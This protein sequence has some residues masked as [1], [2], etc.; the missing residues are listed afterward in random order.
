[1]LWPYRLVFLGLLLLLAGTGLLYSHGDFLFSLL[2]FLVPYGVACV[3]IAYRLAERLSP[4]EWVEP[5]YGDVEP[6]GGDPMP[7]E[8]PG[9]PRWSPAPPRRGGAR[10]PGHGEPPVLEERRGE[11]RGETGGG[12]EERGPCGGNDIIDVL[13]ERDD[14]EAQRRLTEYMECRARLFIERFDEFERGHGLRVDES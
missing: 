6:A 5:E 13:L 10:G 14:P 2:F 11:R 4:V 3:A 9:R 1:M 12:G 8:G 7:V